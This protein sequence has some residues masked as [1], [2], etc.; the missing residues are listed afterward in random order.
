MAVGIAQPCGGVEETACVAVCPV[1]CIHPTKQEAGFAAAEQ[2]YID[3]DPCIICGLCV[4]ECPVSAIFAEDDLP[5]EWA[6]FAER[7]ADYYKRA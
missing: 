2:L 1:D 4:G 6:D 3:P 7:N 5:A